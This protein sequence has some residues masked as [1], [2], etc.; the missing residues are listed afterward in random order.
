MNE[1]ELESQELEALADDSQSQL[2][3]S[4]ML[5]SVG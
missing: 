2:L 4:N 3:Y 5:F 1:P